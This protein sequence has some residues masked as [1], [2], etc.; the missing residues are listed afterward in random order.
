LLDGE[1]ASRLWA[2]DDQARVVA[3]VFG[4]RDKR[5]PLAS[6]GKKGQRRKQWGS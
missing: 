4:R 2:H 5:T 6:T 3:P 1:A